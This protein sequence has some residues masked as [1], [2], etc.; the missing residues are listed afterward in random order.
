M[1]SLKRKNQPNCSS[2]ISTYQLTSSSGCPMAFFGLI[3][4]EGQRKSEFAA[5]TAQGTALLSVRRSRR[6]RS[7]SERSTRAHFA[8]KPPSDVMLSA[9]G[10]AKSAAKRQQAALILQLHHQHLQPELPLSVFVKHKLNKRNNN[11]INFFFFLIILNDHW[12]I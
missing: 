9:F 8:A 3:W 1:N 12:R 7:R 10:H 11:C 2:I 5:S 6:S 4:L